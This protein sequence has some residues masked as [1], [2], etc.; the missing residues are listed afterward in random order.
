M[1]DFAFY[2][3]VFTPY[4]SAVIPLS[5]RSIFFADAVYDVI[6]GRCGIPYQIDEHLERLMKNANAIGLGEEALKSEIIEAIDV[7]L[8]EAEVDDFM[9]YIQLSARPQG[10]AFLILRA[11]GHHAVLAQTDLG[12]NRRQHLTGTFTA[13]GDDGELLLVDAVGL[14]NFPAPAAV[15]DIIHQRAGGHALVGDAVSGEFG[16][17]KIHGH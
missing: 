12:G 7:L 13:P 14:Q 9:L 1:R 6:L 5:D 2:N 11:H 17:E 15:L 10:S 4:D 16:N 8:E 3:G